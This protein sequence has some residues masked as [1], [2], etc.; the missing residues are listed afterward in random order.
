MATTIIED[1]RQHKGKYNKAHQ[2]F[3]EN[4]ID[5]KRSKLVVGDYSLPPK[6]SVDT[7]KGFEELVG[8]FCSADRDRVK[9]EIMEAKELGTELIFLVIDEK[10]KSIEDAKH[11]KNKHGK[12]SGTTLYKTLD[13]FHKRYG[14]RFEFC[15]EAE[16]GKRIAELLGVEE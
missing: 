7:K 14:V 1:T 9:K 16:S 5:L 3:K 12:V 11:W 6:R 15:T 10:A 13:T 4:H 2:F 8:N